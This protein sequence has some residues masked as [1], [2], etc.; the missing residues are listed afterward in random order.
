MSA[1][2]C[3]GRCMSGHGC[4]AFPVGR[5]PVGKPGPRVGKRVEPMPLS[6]K[7]VR[8]IIREELDRDR[9]QRAS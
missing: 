2:Y 9:E 7:D 4:P 6:E 1:C 5:P 8:R 3:T